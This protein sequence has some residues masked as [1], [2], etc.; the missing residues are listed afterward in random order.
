MPQLV[1]RCL[2]LGEAEPVASCSFMFLGHVMSCKGFEERCV[3]EVGE[4]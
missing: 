3:S 1:Q 4:A 2:P